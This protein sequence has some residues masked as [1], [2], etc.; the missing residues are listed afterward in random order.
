MNKKSPN[1]GFP[2]LKYCKI[3]KKDSKELK[4]ERFFK[5]DL[6]KNINI[7][8]ILITN[9]KNNKNNILEKQTD[10]DLDVIKEL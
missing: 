10:D 7:K 5:S 6:K 8:D 3:E 4:K 9:N 1:G 2:P